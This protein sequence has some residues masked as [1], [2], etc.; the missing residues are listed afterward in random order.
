MIGNQML[1]RSYTAHTVPPLLTRLCLLSFDRLSFVFVSTLYS[2]ISLSLPGA[3]AF[4]EKEYSFDRMQRRR[5]RGTPTIPLVK[6]FIRPQ[7]GGLYAIQFSQQQQ[8]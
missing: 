8:Q 4:S 5:T 1:T 2:F 6:K 3:C 7:L